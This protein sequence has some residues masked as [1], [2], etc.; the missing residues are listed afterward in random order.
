M[1]VVKLGKY[2]IAFIVGVIL[3]ILF[4]QLIARDIIVQL[5]SYYRIFHDNF[6]QIQYNTSNLIVNIFVYRLKEF[7]ILFIMN[8]FPIG[9][10]FNMIYLMAKGFINTVI[11]IGLTYIYNVKSGI[12]YI[13]Y[14]FP[15]GILC[16]FIIIYII[17][18]NENLKGIWKLDRTEF[19]SG[20]RISIIFVF[21][22]LLM[23]ETLI[24]A[25]V[26]PIVLTKVFSYLQYV[27]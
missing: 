18:N 17:S 24:E 12:A 14:G 22:M 25:L 20:K 11:I 5:S 6:T 9:K 7:G 2:F 19:K 4:H 26:T 8:T 23:A 21:V 3:G 15:H 13:T 16:I 1:S 27:V 10:A